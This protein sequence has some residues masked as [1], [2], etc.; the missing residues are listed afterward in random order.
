MPTES[1]NTEKLSALAR[2][3][4]I[5]DGTLAELIGKCTRTVK[6]LEQRG[7]LPQSFKFGGENCFLVG[8]ILDHFHRRSE[9]AQKARLERQALIESYLP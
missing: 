8:E 6:R 4:I 7:H 2:E 5:S 3:T 1:F 9:E